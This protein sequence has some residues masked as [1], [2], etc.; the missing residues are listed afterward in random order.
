M[1]PREL[2]SHADLLD[3]TGNDAFVRYDIPPDF[4]GPAW[5]LGGAVIALRRTHTRRLGL[6]V[7]G[8]PSD[9]E[10]LVAH[11]VADGSLARLGLRHVTVERG[12]LH[13][14]AEH[15][16]LGTGNEWEWMCAAAAPARVPAEDRL[17][18]LG[19]AD[20]PEIA[21]LLA[22]ANPR[23][24]ARPFQYP[25]QRWVG[26][27]D[28]AGRLAACGLCEPNV[29]GHPTLSGITVRP[30]QRGRGLGLAVTAYLTRAAVR[31]S[32]V[33]TLGMYSDN[34]VARRV[35]HGLGYTGDHLW[36]SRR[37]LSGG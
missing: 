3:A 18:P 26:V 10:A 24:D 28:D 36:S 29:A 1:R 7:L 31:A 14:V 34:D 35:Y 21:E 11:V 9:V 32:G 30:S 13:A 15:L 8:P 4:G 25:H 33:C 2:T 20:R 27:R 12:S 6:A 22:E 5:T 17:V 19:E 37:V 16:T 23:T